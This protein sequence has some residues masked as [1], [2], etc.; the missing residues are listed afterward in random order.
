MRH[1]ITALL[2]TLLFNQSALAQ[3][4][5]EKAIYNTVQSAYNG[6]SFNEGQKPDYKMMRSAFLDSA[7]FRSYRSGKADVFPIEQYMVNYRS[8]VEG[9]AFKAIREK[10]IWGQTQIF[11]KV[12]H[13]FSTYVLYVN[14]MTTI[15]ERGVN[16][17][18]LVK[19]AE[20]WKI[21]SITYDVE[22][23]GQAIP[24]TYLPDG[25]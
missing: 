16:S 23:D 22:R 17:M 1:I 2:A 15:V 7:I 19:T 8:A 11:G 21:N 18:Q 13:R 14:D 25:R 4:A 24:K 5:E 6:L 10:E 9:G 3:S 12:A 20:G